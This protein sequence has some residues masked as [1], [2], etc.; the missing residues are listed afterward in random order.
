MRK[1]D[2]LYVD[3]PVT[4]DTNFVVDDMMLR[5]PNLWIPGKKPIGP[6][7]IDFSHYLSDGLMAY[8]LFESKAPYCF[9]LERNLVAAGTNINPTNTR[10]GKCIYSTD[11]YF[12]LGNAD[13]LFPR[14]LSTIVY[15]RNRKDLVND[16]VGN[17]GYAD[18]QTDRVSVHLLW[19]EV[20]YF[21]FGSTGTSNRINIA[22]ADTT[23]YEI[24]VFVAGPSK[25]REIWKNGIK[26]I[27]D[28]AKTGSRLSNTGDFWVCETR[29]LGDSAHEN[30]Y[31]FG[32]FDREWSDGQIKSFSADPYQFL[33]PA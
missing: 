10:Y 17:F 1:F 19:T 15:I 20:A 23:D 13:K 3:S 26:L 22:D 12:N 18:S 24:W 2:F 27:G 11:G 16:T 6:V 30:V 29:L 9:G 14:S 25:G 21:D 32:I 7:K 4:S 5:E 31:V 28:A 33:I 8:T